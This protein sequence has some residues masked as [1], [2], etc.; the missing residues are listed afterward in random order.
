MFALDTNI[1]IAALNDRRLGVR[2][3]YKAE[4]AAGSLIVV[5]SI[6][7]MELEYGIARSARQAESRRVLQAFLEDGCDIAAF[8]AADAAEAGDIRGRLAEL[9]T[10]IGPYDVLIAAH[11]RRAGAT[12]VTANTREFA[13]VPGLKLEDWGA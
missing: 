9:G 2:T 13:R 11:A 5:S 7:L 4:I 8:S 12:L 3:R 1:V 6:V 10:P